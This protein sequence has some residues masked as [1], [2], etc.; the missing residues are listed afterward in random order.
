MGIVTTAEFIELR[1]SGR[2]AK[3]YRGVYALYSCFGWAPLVTGY[4]T[5]WMV[6]E[7]QPILGWS[8]FQIV[9]SCGLLVLGYTVLSGL[10]GVAYAQVFQFS[11]YLLGALLLVPRMI[12]FFGGWH[13][14]V[15]SALASRGVQFMRPLPPTPSITYLV[16]LALFIQGFFFAANPTAGE[17]STAQRFM[18]ARDE[19]HAAMGQLL[20]AFLALVVRLIPFVI[21]GI[22]AASLFPKGSTPPELVWGRLVVKFAPR[23]L[24]GLVVAA[25]LA[26]YMAIASAYMN[27]GGSFLTND[28]YKRFIGPQAS[29][30]RLATVGRLTTVAITGLS[31]LVALFLVERMMSWFLYINA[32]MIAFVLPLA[33]LRFFWWRLNIWGEAAGVLLGLPLGYLIW[34]PMGFSRRPFWL[35]FFVLFFAGWVVILL[36]TYLTRPENLETLQVFYDRCSPAGL[37][38]PLTRLLPAAKAR[39]A[40]QEIRVQLITCLIGV[41][42]CASMVVSLNALFAGWSTLALG[43]CAVMLL[44]GLAF[45]RRWRSASIL[46]TADVP[47]PRP[48]T[49]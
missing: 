10:F 45:I 6:V 1:Y 26:G 21:Y 8:K 34:F 15:A 38:G 11:L 14:T 17:G 20:S 30:R 49:T 47:E 9:L 12:G 41:L 7:M 35:G 39:A 24:L 25:E 42:L 27:W 23:G 28:V 18:A 32:V 5:G 13:P 16:V 31:F 3:A 37:W 46:S 44:S 48:H 33:W 2:M 40:R 19:T 4:M 43:S 22:A 36:A 29:D